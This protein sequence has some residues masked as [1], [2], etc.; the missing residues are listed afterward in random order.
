G[1][2]ENPA[3][4]GWDSLDYQKEGTA[5]YNAHG[6]WLIKFSKVRDSWVQHVRT[7]RDEKNVNGS[8][9][10]SNGI[11]LSE[12]RGVTISHCV[13]QKPQ[14]GGAGG[15]GYMYRL[16]HANENLIQYSEAAYS[17]HG[18]VFSF[19]STSGNV[20]HRCIDRYTA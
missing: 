16:N 17:R 7:F 13:F 8:H 12:T 4:E 10:L 14:Y 5:A 2:V 9:L 11:L 3:K 6:S 19:F 18:F 1:N 20:I 15:N